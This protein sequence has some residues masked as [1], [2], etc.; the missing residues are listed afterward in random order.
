MPVVARV[1]G[2]AA[3]PSTFATAH[4]GH[5]P[6]QLIVHAAGGLAVLITAT[7]LSI[8]KPWGRTRYGRRKQ[9]A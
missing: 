5:V 6:I 9:A 8:Y 2:I 3:D 4:L 7:T 1:S